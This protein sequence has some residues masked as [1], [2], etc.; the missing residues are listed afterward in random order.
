YEFLI[1]RA[2][3]GKPQVGDDIPKGSSTE[4]PKCFGPGSD[5]VDDHP[6]ILVQTIHDTHLLV[7]NKFTIFRPQL[8][9]LTVDSYRRQ[10]E[11]LTFEELRA[12]WAVLTGIGK[13][14]YVL[15]NC[16][17]VAGASRMH[18]HMQVIPH[19]VT[20]NGV[21]DGFQFFPD[22]ESSTQATAVPFKN[23]IER[24]RGLS[25][26]T[27]K[28]DQQIF[29]MYLRLLAQTRAAL[30]IPPEDPVC[31]HN[32]VLTQDWMILIPRR[33]KVFHG[34]TANAAG[35]MGSVWLMK[36]SEFEEWKARGPANVLAA[37]GVPVTD[38]DQR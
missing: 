28:R 19:P 37:L 32:V 27:S 38:S 13:K 22:L 31:P 15:F 2:L 30:S 11:P 5:I 16:T 9:L 3:S 12:A 33:S 14:Y 29:E 21:E 1:S 8:L 36:Q 23:F 7:L 18:K 10:T 34:I 4:N 17:P 24:C 25:G 6:K 20:V 35:M 26:E